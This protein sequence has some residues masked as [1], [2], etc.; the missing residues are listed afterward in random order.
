M[1][2]KLILPVFIIALIA[3][4]K[5]KVDTQKE[6]EILMQLDREWSRVAATDSID[7]IMSYW[8]DDAIFY[9]A[10]RPTLNGKAAIRAMVD[11]MYKVPGFK[12][13]WEPI[14]VDVSESGDMAYILEKNAFTM[15][16]STGKAVTTY[17]RAVTVWKKD[18][19]GNWKNIVEVGVDD[20]E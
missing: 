18:K 2:T 11:G 20:P 6:G 14:K 1:L 8:A 4:N 15:N 17:G 13:S 16:D 5:P 3:C 7:K 12:I 10:D 19:D 9:S